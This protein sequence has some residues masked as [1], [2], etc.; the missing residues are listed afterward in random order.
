MTLAQ[1]LATTNEHY[2]PGPII[3]AARVVLG[4]IDLDPA[5]CPVANETVRAASIYTKA[6]DGLSRAW[7]GRVWLNPPGGIVRWDGAR[8]AEHKGGGG[9]SQ[10]LLFWTRLVDEWR[11]GRTTAAVFLGF[12]LEIIRLSQR[13]PLPRVQPIPVPHFIRCYPRDRI[14]FGGD[15]GPAP[16][17]A[18]VIAYLPPRGA[19]HAEHFERFR[20]A[21]DKF[22]LCEPGCNA[23][24]PII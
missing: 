8:W 19:D 2:T 6:D 24:A 22:G 9:E 10:T 3:E 11:H 13:S 5:S 1:H 4:G 12:T 7:P 17:H 21:F 18:N 15:G 20:T 23:Y 14:R 16:T